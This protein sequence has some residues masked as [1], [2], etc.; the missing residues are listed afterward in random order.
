MRVVYIFSRRVVFEHTDCKQDKVFVEIGIPNV[1]TQ[2][3]HIDFC[4]A[5]PSRSEFIKI[6]PSHAVNSVGPTRENP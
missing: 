1:H 5:S 2:G 3:H 6:F 4:F